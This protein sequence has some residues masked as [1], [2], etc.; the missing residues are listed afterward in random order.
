MASLYILLPIALLF[1]IAFC[2]LF[3]WAVNCRQFEDLERESRRILYDETYLAEPEKDTRD[4]G[5]E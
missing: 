5:S 2:G 1:F 3:L 4:R